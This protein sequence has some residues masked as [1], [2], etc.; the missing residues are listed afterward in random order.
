MSILTLSRRAS[1]Q[2]VREA[3]LDYTNHLA[4]GLLGGY[5]ASTGRFFGAPA[6]IGA[7]FG[8]TPRMVFDP[9]FGFGVRRSDTF[10]GSINQ[11]D[12]GRPA[13]TTSDVTILAVARPS[14]STSAG[15]YLATMGQNA[16]AVGLSIRSGTGTEAKYQMTVYIG[17]TRTI[18]GSIPV[19][20]GREVA[21]V[22][23]RHIRNVEQALF[24]NGVKDPAVGNFTGSTINLS[25]FG[26]S[27]TGPEQETYM[28]LV[29]DR[30]LSDEEIARISADPYQIFAEP[31]RPMFFTAGAP[32]L[33]DVSLAG[34][35]QLSAVANGA[36]VSSV[37]LGGG[38]A[39]TASAW[40][41]LS[42][43]LP[44][45][46]AASAR[47]TAGGVLSTS[48]TLAGAAVTGASASGALAGEGVSLGGAVLVGAGLAGSLSTAIRL[49]GAATMSASAAGLLAGDGAGLAGAAAAR[50]S[51]AGE[52][53]TAIAL[54]GTASCTVVASGQLAGAGVIL[55]G[56]VLG[57][58]AAAG[59]LSTSISLAGIGRS[60]SNSVGLLATSVVLAG[61]ARASAASAGDLQ[62]GTRYARAPAGAGYAPRRSEYQARPEQGGHQARP[63]QTGGARPTATQ[64]AYR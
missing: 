31:G 33:P 8:G 1:R 19:S 42:T 26:I 48:I 34:T 16:G 25:F 50:V 54:T 17:T 3:V 44:L 27:G 7:R 5:L 18:G 53:S 40:A 12:T 56:A 51:A 15:A 41:S 62:V 14:T 11:V 32:V 20:P 57:R 21:V 29:W 43:S 39:T 58:A 4:D 22:V 64:K 38:A 30:A 47:V 60:A 52:L 6:G 55:S 24:V 36:L 2:P 23:G 49:A 9:R 59:M 10:G 61:L 13:L 46:G 37:R 28:L 45:A 63:G 35:A